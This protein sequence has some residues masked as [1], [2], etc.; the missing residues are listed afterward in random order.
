MPITIYSTPSCPYCTMAKEY[1]A[2]KG[3]AFNEVNVAGDREK[4]REM[5]FKSGQLGVPVIEING[6]IITGFDRRAIDSALGLPH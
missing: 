2:Q 4:A 1:F 6:K 3:V 5:F